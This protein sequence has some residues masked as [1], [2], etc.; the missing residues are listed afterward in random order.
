[1]HHIA[2]LR[3]GICATALASTLVLAAA[4]G[5]DGPPQKVKVPSDSTSETSP[6]TPNKDRQN[7]TSS[8]REAE[9]TGRRLCVH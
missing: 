5:S 1:M 2:Y 4:C 7:C 8:F 3:R 6:Q 9:L